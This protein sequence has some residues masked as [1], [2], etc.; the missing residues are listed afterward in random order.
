MFVLAQIGLF[1]MLMT[2]FWQ[3]GAETVLAEDNP[4]AS[5]VVVVTEPPVQEPLVVGPE[6]A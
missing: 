2:R 4:L 6:A 5:A 1:L 3:R